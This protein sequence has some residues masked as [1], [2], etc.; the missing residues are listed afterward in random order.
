VS[1]KRDLAGVN[2]KLSD[3]KPLT[4][5]QEQAFK[6]KKHLVL[7]GSAGTGKTFIAFYLAFRELQN[8]KI[9]V[10]RSAVPTRDMG[11]L[12]GTDREKSK[13]YEE[14]YYKICSELFG[15]DDAYE[16][17]KTKDMVSFMTTSFLRGLTLEDSLIIVDECQNCSFHE[18]DSIITRVGSNYQIL[19]CGDFFQSDLRKTE[20]NGLRE[21]LEI[22]AKMEE[23][24]FIEFGLED[25]VR[26]NLVKS[27][28]TIKH[29]I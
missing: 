15:R 13:V 26:S 19:F 29:S 28:L 2:F 18:L 16:I 20:K 11:F 14:P 25:I 9:V 21:F 27:Y 5:R 6:S 7:H 10:V 8:Q 3:V 23:F 4:P 17:L 1:K 12:P 24:D 22:I